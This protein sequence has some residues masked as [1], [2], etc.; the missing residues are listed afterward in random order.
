MHRPHKTHLPGDGLLLLLQKLQLAQGL[1]A[2]KARQLTL[3]HYI[4]Q[5][6]CATSTRMCQ[7]IRPLANVTIDTPAVCMKVAVACTPTRHCGE[8]ALLAAGGAA[9]DSIHK[10]R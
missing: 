3:D 8:P 2:E 7:H 5:V 4:G 6:G 9:A 1:E 10:P